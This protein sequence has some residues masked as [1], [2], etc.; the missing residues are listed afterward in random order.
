MHVYSDVVRKNSCFGCCTKLPNNNADGLVRSITLLLKE[1]VVVEHDWILKDNPSH[2]RWYSVKT[3]KV[4]ILD[5]VRGDILAIVHLNPNDPFALSSFGENALF[6]SAHHPSPYNAKAMTNC[7][8]ISLEPNSFLE[9]ESNYKPEFEAMREH[10]RLDNEHGDHRYSTGHANEDDNTH[11]VSEAIKKENNRFSA[12]SGLSS[13][14][15]L[16]FQSAKSHRF[17]KLFNALRGKH[18]YGPESNFQLI[19]NTLIMFCVI[20]EMMIL[21]F[22]L[23]FSGGP[24]GYFSFLVGLDYLSDIVFVVDSR[25]R[26]TGFSFLEGDTIVSDVSKIRK[27]YLNKGHKITDIISVVPIEVLSFAIPTSPLS[28]VQVFS[29]FR[30]LRILR[31]RHFS[32][33]VRESEQALSL[34]YFFVLTL[35]PPRLA[36]FVARRS[37]APTSSSTGQLPTSPRTPSRCPS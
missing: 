29:L 6:D 17:Q 8:L 27:N 14:D 34:F 31:L 2:D 19:W 24:Y 3:G 32:E 11:Q 20:Y 30:F 1:E 21:P 35:S 18:A 23:C 26:Y 7:L 10:L 12:L 37:G 9:L 13:M 36:S 16:A 15:L 4:H 5:K 28:T 22:R 33:Q 25:F